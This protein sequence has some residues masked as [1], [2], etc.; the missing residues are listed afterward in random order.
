MQTKPCGVGESLNDHRRDAIFVDSFCIY[1][2]YG[3]IRL[4]LDYLFRL[5]EYCEAFIV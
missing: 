3:Q 2:A 5:I 4:D 1:F